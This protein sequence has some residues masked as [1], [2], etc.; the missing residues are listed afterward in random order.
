[1]ASASRKKQYLKKRPSVVE[2]RHTGSN[3]ICRSV[4]LSFGAVRIE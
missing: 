3:D 4:H 2:K 1:M